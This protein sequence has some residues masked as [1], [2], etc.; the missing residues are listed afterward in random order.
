[1]YEITFM[2]T[3]TYLIFIISQRADQLVARL[4]DRLDKGLHVVIVL[5]LEEVAGHGTAEAVLLDVVAGLDVDAASAAGLGHELL[6]GDLVVLLEHQE[7]VAVQAGSLAGSSTDVLGDGLALG[8]LVAGNV[9]HQP[10]EQLTE[11]G[12]LAAGCVGV[13]QQDGVQGVG[14]GIEDDSGLVLH[15]SGSQLLAQLNL[16]A[17]RIGDGGLG[18]GLDVDDVGNN[19]G[20]VHVSW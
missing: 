1:M 20:G 3:S 10:V 18:G 15:L 2:R 19:A 11:L 6:G 13:H 14:L 4:L 16:N 17:G 9:D 5:G 8:H 7:D 12:V